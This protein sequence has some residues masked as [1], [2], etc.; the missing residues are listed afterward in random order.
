MRF[1]LTYIF[2]GDIIILEREVINMSIF[3]NVDVKV[4]ETVWETLWDK[5]EADTATDAE[6]RMF[7]EL[8]RYYDHKKKG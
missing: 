6:Q 2:I 8:G 1:L 3:D 4:L 5:V 7:W